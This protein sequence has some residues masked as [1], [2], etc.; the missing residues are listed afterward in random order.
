M[1]PPH[2]H[3]L[4]THIRT[5]HKWFIHNHPTWNT[6]FS[7][8]PMHCKK[9]CS[10]WGSTQTVIIQ[11]QSN[12]ESTFWVCCHCQHKHE[13]ERPIR[14][15]Y[16]ASISVYVHWSEYNTRNNFLQFYRSIKIDLSKQR[17]V[18]VSNDFKFKTKLSR[19]F[20]FTIS[21]FSILGLQNKDIFTLTQNRCS[22]IIL[23]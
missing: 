17:T 3:V 20:I 7:F 10:P 9:I 14:L 5:I 6:A 19:I 13:T 16:H 1:L 2:I 4:K 18:A 8:I 22:R 21:R 12:T 11:N 23:P 15:D